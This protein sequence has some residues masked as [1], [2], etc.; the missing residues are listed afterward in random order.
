VP[1]QLIGQEVD[2][3]ITE[4]VIEVI[5]KGNRIRGRETIRVKNYSRSKIF[6]FDSI[7][8]VFLNKT[9]LL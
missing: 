2:L 9:S 7:A 6:T 8:K 3:R 5:H 1:Y 4:K